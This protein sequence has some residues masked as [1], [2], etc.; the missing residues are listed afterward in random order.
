MRRMEDQNVLPQVRAEKEMKKKENVC[1]SH[2]GGGSNWDS[3][4]INVWLHTECK[5]C[6]SQFKHRSCDHIR[7]DLSVTGNDCGS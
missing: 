3:K 4:L 5:K 1:L 7:H 2:A 6:G